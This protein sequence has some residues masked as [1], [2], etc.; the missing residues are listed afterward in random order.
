[1]GMGL[2]TLWPQNSESSR[3]TQ[4]HLQHN[5]TQHNA[6]QRNTIHYYTTV[7]KHTHTHT[8]KTQDS[9]KENRIYAA[10][11]SS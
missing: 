6:T 5:T 1:M 3:T 9:I 2:Q 11:Q 7:E 4:F 10:L 8:H